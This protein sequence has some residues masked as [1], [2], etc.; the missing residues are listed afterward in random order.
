MNRTNWPRL[1]AIAALLVLV[2]LACAPGNARWAGETR[3][4]FWAGLW[5]GLIIIITFIVSLFTSEVRIYEANNIG[6]GYN[7]GFIIG[8]M[9][10][11]GGGARVSAKR[12]RKPDYDR[13]GQRVAESVR[14]QIADEVKEDIEWDSF[15]R[16]VEERIREE[17]R[18]SRK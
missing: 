7:L 9:I 8:A 5:H 3:A 4:N 12:R 1:A 2:C 16:K 6:W 18:A 11:L 14:R 10:S 17:F 15:S 13:I